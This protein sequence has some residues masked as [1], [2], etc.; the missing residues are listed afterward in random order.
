MFLSLYLFYIF[1]TRY[2]LSSDNTGH[3]DKPQ[4]LL[5]HCPNNVSLYDYEVWEN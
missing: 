4:K 2:A 5:Q 1:P 3:R